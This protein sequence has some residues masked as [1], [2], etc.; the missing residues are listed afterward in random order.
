[1][2]DSV[3]A[4]EVANARVFYHQ[5]M[6]YAMLFYLHKKYTRQK[7]ALHVHSEVYSEHLLLNF[8][9]SLCFWTSDILYV[10]LHTGEETTLNFL[11]IWWN[12]SFF[13]VQ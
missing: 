3:T 11:L 13:H 5:Q 6:T 10:L 1:M 9:H 2:A 4:K 12:N 7:N 8:K